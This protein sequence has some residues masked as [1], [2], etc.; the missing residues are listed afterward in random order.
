MDSWKEELKNTEGYILS[1]DG[2]SVHLSTKELE[3]F[4]S[5]AIIEAKIEVLNKRN[6]VTQGVI[7]KDTSD[8]TDWGRGYIC[9]LEESI[10][11]NEEIIEELEQ[12]KKQ[13]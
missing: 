1:G 12:L 9:G 2:L 7:D 10:Y 11:C 13:S 3:S 6:Q 8:K 5:K 4:I